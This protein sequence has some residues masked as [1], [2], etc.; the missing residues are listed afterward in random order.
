MEKRYAKGVN[1][2]CKINMALAN[3][4]HEMTYGLEM[5]ALKSWN[6]RFAN[7]IW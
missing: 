5:I 6:V 1:A 2:K 7:M 3:E 4:R